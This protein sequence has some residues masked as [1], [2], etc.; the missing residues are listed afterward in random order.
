MK[1][2]VLSVIRAYVIELDYNPDHETEL[3]VRSY[4]VSEEELE[5]E[6]GVLVGQGWH[7]IWEIFDSEE[8]AKKQAAILSEDT[9]LKY[10]E[11]DA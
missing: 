6:Q 4:L 1:S 8:A 2:E 11:D 5:K 10:L 7:P 9:G 3:C